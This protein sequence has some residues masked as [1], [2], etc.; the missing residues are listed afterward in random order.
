MKK[1]ALVFA[2]L[3]AVVALNASF[4]ST[5]VGKLKSKEASDVNYKVKKINGLYSIK[6][7]DFMTETSSL[8][9]DA[10][11]QYN[12]PFKEKYITVLDESKDDVEAFRSDYGVSDDS[13]SDL[14]NYADMRLQYLTESGIEIKDQTKLKASVINGH[15]ALSTMIDAT[16]PGIDEDITYYFTYVEGADHFYMI[17]AWTLLSRKDTYTAEVKVMAESFQEL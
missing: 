6:I 10:S 11:L 5:E 9:P 3:I 13:K 17:S 16:V 15:K 2:L 7:P 8:Q 12:N 4:T 14:E 1:I